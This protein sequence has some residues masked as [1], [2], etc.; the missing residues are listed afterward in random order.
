MYKRVFKQKKPLY[1]MN[2]TPNLMPI[3][4]T[5][6]KGGCGKKKGKGG[7][8]VG[9]NINYLNQG[10]VKR[11]LSA[12]EDFVKKW[13]GGKGI[14]PQGEAPR[15]PTPQEV[16]AGTYGEKNAA[17][18]TKQI[19]NYAGTYPVLKP[20]ADFSMA[21]MPSRVDNSAWENFKKKSV[22][23]T[24]FNSSTKFEKVHP[25]QDWAAPK[26]TKFDS[27]VSGKVIEVRTGQVNNPSIGSFGNYIVILT[28]DGKKVKLSH[29][30]RENVKVGDS[31][32]AGQ[33]D[34]VE[35]GDSGGAYSQNGGDPSHLDIRI[36]DAWNRYINP[37][38]YL[39]G[40]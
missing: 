3:P 18:S 31:V 11:D 8:E 21:G 13:K 6:G 37:D 29:L 22:L 12:E 40:K 15:L 16:N 9:Q 14:L 25:A 33:S 10:N 35:I 39:S 19:Q 2:A 17:F 34:I 26:G 38:Q 32:T 30:L 20:K 23:T 5:G 24:P 1:F 36:L 7:A 28:P 4:K 27:P